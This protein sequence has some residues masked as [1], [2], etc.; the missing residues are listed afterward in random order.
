M[1]VIWKAAS[2]NLLDISLWEQL[3]QRK[4]AATMARIPA[5]VRSMAYYCGGIGVGSRKDSIFQFLE[6]ARGLLLKVTSEGTV[7]GRTTIFVGN[8]HGASVSPQSR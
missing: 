7:S 5:D 3:H 1:V 8:A 4:E 2:V 6:G